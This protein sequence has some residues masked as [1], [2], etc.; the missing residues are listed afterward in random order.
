MTLTPGLLA[1][2]ARDLHP[3]FTEQRVPKALCRRAVSRWQQGIVARVL[4]VRPDVLAFTDVAIAL[5]WA[6]FAV[7]A[8]LPADTICVR[9]ATATPAS[10]A[11]VGVVEPVELFAPGSRFGRVHFP[12]LVIDGTVARPVGVSADWVGYSGLTVS[13]LR[14]PPLL[15][16]DSASL[17]LPDDALEAGVRA[18]GAFMAERLLADATPP[19]LD[20]GDYQ[21]RAAAAEQAF[22]GRIAVQAATQTA[23]IREVW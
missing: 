15:A 23:R 19:I 10:P 6:N 22:L 20:L 16:N 5:P 3:A 2:H 8:D 11:V 18:L 1:E 9:D 4:A 12:A 13:C 14:L 17:V 21:G 7:G